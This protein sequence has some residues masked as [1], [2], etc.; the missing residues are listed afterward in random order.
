MKTIELYIPSTCTEHRAAIQYVRLCYTI[1][2][3]LSSVNHRGDSLHYQVVVPVG[4]N[5]NGLYLGRQ[6]TFLF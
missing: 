5:S 2:L 6:P 1:V 4:T 3:L